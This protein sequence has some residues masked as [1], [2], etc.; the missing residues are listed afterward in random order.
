[1]I[2]VHST[3]TAKGPVWILPL[4][5]KTTVISPTRETKHDLEIDFLLDSGASLNLLNKA[6]WDEI[7]FLNPTL[8][9]KEKNT[10]IGAAN[11]SQLSCYGSIIIKLNSDFMNQGRRFRNEEYKIKFTVSNT[12]HNILG[13]PF[14]ENHVRNIDSQLKQLTMTT[15]DKYQQPNIINFYGETTKKAPY[16][17]RLYHVFNDKNFYFKPEES[18]RLTFPL[19]TFEPLETNSQKQYLHTSD[20]SFQPLNKNLDFSITCLLYTSDAADDSL[21]V[22]LGGRRIIK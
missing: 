12:S 1:M 13:T 6:T 18:R 19:S 9:L 20:F 7:Q 17:S 2:Q 10:Q 4:L 8:K 15:N 5:Y 21:R 3:R 22:D 14:I 11:G 16:Y